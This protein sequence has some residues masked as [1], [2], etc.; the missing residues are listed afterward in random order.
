M[1]DTAVKLSRAYDIYNQ[2]TTRADTLRSSSKR[3]K[4][5]LGSNRIDTHG[6]NI[7][8]YL[9]VGTTHSKYDRS[10]A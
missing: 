5:S 8:A 9:N 3:L 1:D 10:S 4:S 7:K 6:G 2:A